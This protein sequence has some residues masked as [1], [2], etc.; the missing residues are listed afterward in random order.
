[1]RRLDTGKTDKEKEC[2]SD[3]SGWLGNFSSGLFVEATPLTWSLS[4]VT[5]TDMR[6]DGTRVENITIVR[7]HEHDYPACRQWQLFALGKTIR[8]DASIITLSFEVAFHSDRGRHET[9]I[10]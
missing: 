4:G 6:V 3:G 7:W 10:E 5:L 2:L 1:M 9:N 8:C